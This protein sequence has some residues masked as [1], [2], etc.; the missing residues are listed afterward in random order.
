MPKRQTATHR[1]VARKKFYAITFCGRVVFRHRDL[2]AAHQF[3][4]EYDPRALERI[5]RNKALKD[6]LNELD[7]QIAA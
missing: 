1:I 3:L 5:E 6:S 7:E 4:R 2:N